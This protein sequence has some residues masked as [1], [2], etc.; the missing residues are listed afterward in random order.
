MEEDV[1]DCDRKNERPKEAKDVQTHHE[2]EEFFCFRELQVNKFLSGFQR[3]EVEVGPIFFMEQ[4]GKMLV[5]ELYIPV[6]L[7]TSTNLLA[8]NQLLEVDD[9]MLDFVFLLFHV[10]DLVLEIVDVPG[11]VR[12]LKNHL[13]HNFLIRIMVVNEFGF[14]VVAHLFSR[15]WW[16]LWIQ[17]EIF[18]VAERCMF[19]IWLTV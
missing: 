8:N 7:L 6:L 3:V 16:Q 9:T 10:V 14:D 11:H 5:I 15:I 17:N 4:L 18:E 1:V 2:P 12:V 13:A 19:F